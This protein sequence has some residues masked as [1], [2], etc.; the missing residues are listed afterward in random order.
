MLLNYS[1][2]VIR[3]GQDGVCFAE[4]TVFEE[5]RSAVSIGPVEIGTTVVG[6]TGIGALPVGL[7]LRVAYIMTWEV[8]VF[9]PDTMTT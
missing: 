9:G 8:A 5:T 3:I 4:I 1:T 2:Q 6:K 7:V